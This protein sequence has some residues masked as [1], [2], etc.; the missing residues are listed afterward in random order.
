MTYQEFFAG[1]YARLAR[2]RVA[3]LD[4]VASIKLRRAGAWQSTINACMVEV[5]AAAT[6]EQNMVTLEFTLTIGAKLPEAAAK[7]AH[8]V[9]SEANQTIKT[10][11]DTRVDCLSPEAAE[12]FMLALDHRD[13]MT[14]VTIRSDTVSVCKFFGNKVNLRNLPVLVTVRELKEHQSKAKEQ[15]MIT[16]KFTVSS[17]GLYA[18]NSSH[19]AQKT[20]GICKVN[21]ESTTNT[22][23]SLEFK[24]AARAEAFLLKLDL[25]TLVGD[26]DLGATSTCYV[27][28]YRLT[29]DRGTC[30]CASTLHDLQNKPVGL[31]IDWTKPLKHLGGLSVRYVETLSTRGQF[32]H[33]CIAGVENQSSLLYDDHGQPEIG[34]YAVTNRPEVKRVLHAVEYGSS[35]FKDLGPRNLALTWEDGKLIKAE[36]L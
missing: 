31:R 36:V 19:A 2:D 6:K 7:H 33:L 1:A 4:S 3:D 32:K 9:N 8:R 10:F 5:D 21:G 24:S 27:F 22:K 16:V 12:A 23:V 26:I 28:N 35:K 13:L 18:M 30:L 14:G 20:F 29:G 17:A 11:T 34:E 25:D 15:T